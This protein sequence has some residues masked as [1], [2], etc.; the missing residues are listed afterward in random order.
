MSKRRKESAGSS[1]RPGAAR[2][3]IGITSCSFIW[4]APDGREL[5]TVFDMTNWQ[6]EGFPPGFNEALG[7]HLAHRSPAQDAGLARLGR[8]LLARPDHSS[9]GRSDSA[10]DDVPR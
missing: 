1:G 10:G 4:R 9:E 3:P 7:L 2:K 5:K 8:R 6:E